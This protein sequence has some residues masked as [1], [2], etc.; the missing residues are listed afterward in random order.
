MVFGNPLLNPNYYYSNV[1]FAIFQKIKKIGWSKN[2]LQTTKVL[3]FE[4]FIEVGFFFPSILS[5]R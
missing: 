5:S 4:Y 2:N 3:N 1:Y